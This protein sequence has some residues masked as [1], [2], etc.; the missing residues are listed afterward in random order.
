MFKNV[1]NSLKGEKRQTVAAPEM[2]SLFSSV[3]E[4]ASFSQEELQKMMKEISVNDVLQLMSL[5]GAV[6]EC[7]GVDPKASLFDVFAAFNSG[8][9]SRYKLVSAVAKAKQE[10]GYGGGSQLVDRLLNMI[11][12]MPQPSNEEAAPEAMSQV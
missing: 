6:I 12:S 3:P 7:L 8:E 5:L 9:F 11:Q 2:A 1:I 10:I 4:M